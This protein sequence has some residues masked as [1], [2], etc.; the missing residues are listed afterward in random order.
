MIQIKHRKDLHQIPI[1]NPAYPILDE[2]CE[3]LIDSYPPYEPDADGWLVLL[4]E[5]DSNRILTEL[6]DDWRIQDIEFESVELSNGVFS[7]IFLA[8][9][10]KG[11]VICAI[12]GPW[13]SDAERAHLTY[14]IDPADQVS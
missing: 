2:L 14:F 6:W 11:F 7:G 8:N 5:S 12:D 13:L 1:D 9:N 10:Q 3:L 4:E